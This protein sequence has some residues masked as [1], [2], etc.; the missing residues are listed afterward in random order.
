MMIVKKIKPIK[1]SVQN[2]PININEINN[3]AGQNQPGLLTTSND[4]P[5]MTNIQPNNDLKE[6]SLRLERLENLLSKLI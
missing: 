4:S 2:N 1:L 3:M 6:M 5:Q